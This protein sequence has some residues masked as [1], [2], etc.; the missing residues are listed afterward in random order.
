MDDRPPFTLVDALR[1]R[2]R[3]ILGVAAVFCLAAGLLSFVL[4]KT[5]Q[6]TAIMYLDTART[7]T[8]FDAGIAAGD[9][10][11][12]DF[13]VSANS[14]AT[15]KEACA[16]AGA[17]CSQSDLVAPETTIGNLIS[18][19]VYRGTSGLAVIAKGRTPSEAAARANAVAQ[20]MI[21]QDAAEVIRLYQPALDHLNKQLA[22]LT[23]DIDSE[24]K[25]LASTTPGSPAAAAHEAELARLQ[26]A[27]TLALTRQIDLSQREDRLTNI[28]TIVQPALPPAKPESP[29]PALYIGAALLAGLCVGLF[30][31]LLIERFDDRIFSAEGL[32]RAAGIPPVFVTDN[33]RR[34]LFSNP[35]NAYARALANLLARSPDAPRTVLVVAASEKDRGETVAGGLGAVVANAGQRVKVIEYGGHFRASTG[36]RDDPPGLTTITMPQ[37]LSHS[38]ADVAGPPGQGG[39][40]DGEFV[41]MS[42]P[43][44]DVSPV[45]LDLGRSIK[46]SVLVATHGV[47][48]F[49]DVRRTADLLRLSGVDVLAGILVKN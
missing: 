31:A 49:G 25:A 11:Q 17:G 39:S 42:V 12:H 46:H 2:Y 19:S 4:P 8:D 16:A 5:Y 48:H 40:Q 7:A 23:S 47:T 26:N 38:P 6:A 20:A 37:S 15:L 24:Q 13:I 35:N 43:A 10:L 45:A 3:V 28:A 29:N 41:L 9:L 44:P 33:V 18:A 32:A 1:H 21:D 22:Q 36:A 14:R 30:A 34:P 27:Y